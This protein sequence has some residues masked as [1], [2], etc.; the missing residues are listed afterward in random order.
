MHLQGGCI[1]DRTPPPK[2]K[3]D[4][5]SS[6]QFKVL[7]FFL[8]GGGGGSGGGGAG[9]RLT[10]YHVDSARTLARTAPIWTRGVLMLE[11]FPGGPVF[12]PFDRR[13]TPDES[14]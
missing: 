9:R 10:V 5:N 6:V 11:P 8:D 12:S 13:P 1:T 2:K 14:Q 7:G 4:G 3:A